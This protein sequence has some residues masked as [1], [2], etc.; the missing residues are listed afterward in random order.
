MHNLGPSQLEF[1]NMFQQQLPQQEYYEDEYGNESP[2]AELFAQ[3]TGMYEAAMHEA[4]NYEYGPMEA[5][6]FEGEYQAEQYGEGVFQEYQ[7]EVFHGEMNAAQEYSQELYETMSEEEE[8]ALA[9]E[10]LEV[11][12]EEEIDQF[13]GKLFRRVVRGAGRFLRSPV[14][15]VIGGVLRGVARKALPIAGSAIGTFVGGPIGTALGGQLG[16]MA[17]QAMGLETAGMSNEEANFAT[18]RQFIRFA[19]N[20]ARNAAMSVPGRDPN[21]IA[22]DAVRAAAQRFAPGLLGPQAGRISAPTTAV[23]N[24]GVWVRRGSTIVIYGA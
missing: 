3:E 19:T 7:P 22:R 12:S 17:G 23:R 24:R 8:M 21:A 16:S 10:L 18:S 11:Q 6:Q 4:G 20:A 15:R 9:A 14:G 1:P 5:P 13:L 2:L